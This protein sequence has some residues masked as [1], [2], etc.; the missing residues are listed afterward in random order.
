MF[1]FCQKRISRIF[2]RLRTL[3]AKTPGVAYLHGCAARR[4]RQ[5]TQIRLA[6]LTPQMLELRKLENQ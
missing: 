2:S 3:A 5:R 1:V 4:S 6:S